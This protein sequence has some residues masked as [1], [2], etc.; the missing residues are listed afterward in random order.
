MFVHRWN[1]T[2][3]L[4]LHVWQF[5]W[6]CAT[7]YI[8]WHCGTR[9]HWISGLCHL[10]CYDA[11]H[12]KQKQTVL[13]T[14]SKDQNYNANDSGRPPSH[15]R[16]KRIARKNLIRKLEQVGLCERVQH[17][18]RTYACRLWKLKNTDTAPNC[19]Y[20]YSSLPIKVTKR[21]NKRNSFQI[22]D[23]ANAFGRRCKITQQ[24][25]S[26]CESSTLTCVPRMNAGIE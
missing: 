24:T 20:Y 7:S 9:S 23:H 3:H 21:A 16:H 19:Y 18:R 15:Q 13:S 10:R 5:S 4:I 6:L 26:R 8:V 17:A 11:S 25:T 14:R 22:F 2:H 12:T 1:K